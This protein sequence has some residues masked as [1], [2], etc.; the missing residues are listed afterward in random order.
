MNNKNPNYGI[1]WDMVKVKNLILDTQNPFDIHGRE[2]IHFKADKIKGDSNL[3]LAKGYHK[4]KVGII[5]KKRFLISGRLSWFFDHYRLAA[6]IISAKGIIVRKIED[7]PDYVISVDKTSSG[8]NKA[9]K[10][11]IPI[12]SEDEIRFWLEADKII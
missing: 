1:S 4:K 3:I 12:L 9:M 6:K 5:K 7:N 10:L 2:L 11:G 8:Y